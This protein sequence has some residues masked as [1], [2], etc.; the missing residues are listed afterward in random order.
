MDDRDRALSA[1]RP[2]AG[3]A[4]DRLLIV[5][6]SLHGSGFGNQVGMLLQHLSL[7]ALSGR[8][9]VLPPFHIKRMPRVGEPKPEAQKAEVSLDGSIFIATEV[10]AKVEVRALAAGTYG[11]V[12]AQ[13]V[14]GSP[15]READEIN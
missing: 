13:R 12:S 2:M 5:H 15:S 11:K 1:A 4:T 6:P 10:E 3:T 9:L 7:A 14:S 8:A